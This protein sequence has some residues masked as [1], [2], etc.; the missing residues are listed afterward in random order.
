ML[1]RAA[2][3][4][5][6]LLDEHAMDRRG[7]CWRCQ[8]PGS[9]VGAARQRCRVYSLVHDWLHESRPT[10]AARLRRDLGV[11]I[12]PTS[13]G[14]VA[15]QIRQAEAEQHGRRLAGSAAVT[16]VNWVARRSN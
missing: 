8:R 12:P 11:P 15:Y 1:F 3:V 5:Y 6:A 13:P 7:R 9:W 14:V 16:G 4:V 10:L 2:A